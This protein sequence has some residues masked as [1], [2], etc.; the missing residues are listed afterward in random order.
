MEIIKYQIKVYLIL[1]VMNG[2]VAKVFEYRSVMIKV[3]CE[4]V[5][6]NIFISINLKQVD[7]S[8]Y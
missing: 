8:E 2:E 3:V 7:F 1:Q 5:G 6:H 4:E